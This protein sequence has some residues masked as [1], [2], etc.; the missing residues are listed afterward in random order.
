MVDR[1]RKSSRSREQIA[2]KL[3]GEERRKMGKRTQDWL[4]PRHGRKRR[5]SNIG[6]RDS[7]VPPVVRA[8][9]GLRAGLSAP[10]PELHQRRERA[11]A[12]GQQSELEPTFFL[13]R[14]AT[15]MSANTSLAFMWLNLV[16]PVRPLEWNA[17]M[18]DALAESASNHSK[19][20][21]K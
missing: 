20:I 5:D 7:A 13:H 16:K 18:T 2:Y 1:G 10:V 6:A 11:R 14:A 19:H 3:D 4:R 15:C 21:S 9:S 12:C 17:P 8:P